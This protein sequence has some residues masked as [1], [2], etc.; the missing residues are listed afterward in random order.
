MTLFRE[1]IQGLKSY[2]I[3]W[4]ELD[5][6]I[7]DYQVGLKTILIELQNK[8][9]VLVD[10]TLYGGHTVV[11]HG[12]LPEKQKLL[13]TDPNLQFPGVRVLAKEELEM[14]W[15]SSGQCRA[16]VLTKCR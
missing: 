3:N 8:R 7:L 16:L 4:E 1:L 2:G 10:T 9:P 5:F 13:I 14:I 12:Y 6:A 15:N 11:I